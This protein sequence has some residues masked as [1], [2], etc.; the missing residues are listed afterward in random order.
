[1]ADLIHDPENYLAT[2]LAADARVLLINP[3]VEEKRYHWLRWNQPLELLKLSSWL[4]Q[5]HSGISVRL[6][7]F[8][9]PDEGGAVHKHKVKDTLSGAGND[10]QLWHFGRTFENFEA[11]LKSFQQAS[12]V[13]DYIIISSLTSYWHKSIEKLLIKLRNN[14]SR[15][16]RDR[17]RILLYGAYPLFEPEHA[18]S[19]SAADVAMTRNVVTRGCAPDFDLYVDAEKRLPNFFA[20]D[21]DDDAV[22]DHLAMCLGL[23]AR[24]LK[25]RR[26]AKRPVIT[27]AFF[28]D[29]VCGSQ[30]QL[31]RVARF[32]EANPKQLVVEGIAGILPTSLTKERLQELKAAAFRTLF[33]E[34]ARTAGGMLNEAAYAPLL[35][36]L[37]EDTR[38]KKSGRVSAWARPGAVTGFVSIGLPDDEMDALVRSTLFLN[39][40]FQSII[41]KPFGYSPT[42]DS[43]SPSERK[44]RWPLPR[45][46]SPQWFPYVGNGSRLTRTDY[47]NLL[48]WQG[49]LNKRVRSAT[50]DF[51]DGGTV[52]R[53]VRETLLAESWKP[54]GG[55]R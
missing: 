23:Q 45:D 47:T 25:R 30:S 22:E 27:A 5:R 17:T 44:Q 41:L 42:V 19:Q 40:A 9:F 28:N 7:D 39:S 49:L 51:L 14:L 8:M 15:D 16:A 18:A 12:W 32:A 38:D 6:F 20:L 34:H 53:L 4:K 2:K 55:P 3:P 26:V 13:P 36:T 31:S 35:E 43:A 21:I 50:F 11:V 29:D 24:E 10:P 46:S 48:G 54:Q 1:M 52:A 33:V 37:H